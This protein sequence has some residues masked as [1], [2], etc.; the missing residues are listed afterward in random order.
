MSST[1]KRAEPEGEE[2]GHTDFAIFAN[3]ASGLGR[4]SAEIFGI[5]EDL[6]AVSNRQIESFAGLTEQ[7]DELGRANTSIASSAREAEQV[8]RTARGAVSAALEGTRVLAESV[9][10]MEQGVAAVTRALTGVSSAAAE[11][12][13]IA[14]QTRLLAF[15]ASVEAV[16]AGEAG[17][18][19]AVVAQ[20]IKDL[21]Q[22][23]QTSSLQIGK[24]V[25]ALE[26]RI[27]ELARRADGDG[28]GQ[29]RSA[30][31]AVQAAVNTFNDSFDSVEGRISGIANL[32][33]A[34]AQTCQE[35]TQVFGKLNDDVTR[36]GK[37]L[38]IASERAGELLKLSEEL[39]E[40]GAESG[41]ETE[42]SPYIA[43]V[44]KAAKTISVL[45]EAAVERGEITLQELGD[46]RYEEIEGSNPKQYRTRYL[47]FTDRVLPAIQEPLLELS[48]RVVFC[49]AVDRNGYLPTHNR[50]FSAVPRKDPVWNAAN[51]RNRRIFNDRTGLGAARSRKPFLLQTYRRDMG[52]G[53]FV[54][55]K[56]LSAP[57]VVSGRHW[58]GLRLA[59]RF[60]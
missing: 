12:G 21:A 29:A 58:G 5:L 44:R 6:E 11:I 36:T 1:E 56:D 37:N 2:R 16:R 49:A 22:Q 17:R 19:F 26:E 47:D 35:V 38:K 46:V 23:A 59:Y 9:G 39:I 7:A 27:A 40:V 52:G 48:D 30:T 13:A 28:G 34:G 55:M 15:N 42:D 51:C 33:V 32:A 31:D 43:A 53:Q 3:R 50:K 14:F 54:I 41:M 10:S 20:A 45:F 25:S 60:E 8:A 57:I 18:G 24:T 4:E